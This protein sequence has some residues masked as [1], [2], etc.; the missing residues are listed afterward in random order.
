MVTSNAGYATRRQGRF[1]RSGAVRLL[2]QGTFTPSVQAHAGRTPGSPHGRCT[3]KPRSAGDFYV[4]THEEV[5]GAKQS[6]QKT[7]RCFL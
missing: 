3:I 5:S 7:L 6:S 1:T 4:R 2:L